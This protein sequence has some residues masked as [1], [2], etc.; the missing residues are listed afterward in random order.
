MS[1]FIVAEITKNWEDGIPIVDD[2][3]S[4]RFEKVLNTN[5]NRGYELHDWKFSS[6]IHNGVLTETII[7]VFKKSKEKEL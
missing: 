6:V 2:L 7:A 3:L 1:E 4:H 5:L